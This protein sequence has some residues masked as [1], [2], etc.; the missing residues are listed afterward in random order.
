MDC[1]MDIIS[2]IEKHDPFAAGEGFG[3]AGK[4]VDLAVGE[5]G[6]SCTLELNYQLV[7]I[8]SVTS[9]NQMQVIGQDGTGVDGKARFLSIC[10]ETCGHGFDLGPCESHRGTLEGRLGGEPLAVVMGTMRDRTGF[11]GFGR[12]AVAKEFPRTDKRRPRPARIIGKTKPIGAK[13][14][15]ISDHKMNPIVSREASRSEA[16]SGIPDRSALLRNT[17]RLT[18]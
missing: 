6:R 12:G 5:L 15:V 2:R 7:R 11:V 8:E 4:G 17:S 3:F 13:D 10:T 14:D 1:T 9:H 16:A 18:G